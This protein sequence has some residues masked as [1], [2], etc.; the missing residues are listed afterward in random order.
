MKRIFAVVLAVVMVVLMATPVLAREPQMVEDAYAAWDGPGEWEEPGYMTLF[1]NGRPSTPIALTLADGWVYANLQD[2]AYALGA[3]AR[4]DSQTGVVHWNPAEGGIIQ[5]IAFDNIRAFDEDGIAWVCREFVWDVQWMTTGW[6]FGPTP[7]RTDIPPAAPV[8][9]TTDHGQMAVDFI[10]YMNDNLYNRVPFSYRELEAAQWIRDELIAMGYDEDA[11]VLQSF[12]IEDA[13]AFVGPFSGSLGIYEQFNAFDPD[14]RL[15]L[16]SAVDAMI[17]IALEE[18]YEWIARMAEQMGVSF[19]EAL[20]MMAEDHGI[21][22]DMFHKLLEVAVRDSAPW[23]LNFANVFGLFDLDT[24]FRPYSQNVVLT[25][26]GQSERKIVVTAHYDSIMVPGASDNASGTALLLESAYR[27]MDMD[28]YFTIVYVFMGAEEIGLLGA[29]YYVENLSN[30]ERNNIVLNINADVLIEGPYFF[31]GAGIMDDFWLEDNEITL[32]IGDIA[33]ELNDSYGT[34]LIN[35]QP[36]AEMPSDQLPFLWGGHTVVTLVGLAR[37]G[38]EGYEE[39]LN[40]DMY[41]GF[42]SSIVHTEFDCFHFI[43][44]TWPNKI[45]D[46]MWTFSVFL[47][48]LLAAEF[49]YEN[50]PQID[51]NIFE[52]VEREEV[53]LTNHPMVGTWTWDDNPE[54]SYVFNADG[55]GVRGLPGQMVEFYWYADDYDVFIDMENGNIT[56]I[57]QL[58]FVDDEMLILGMQWWHSFS[59]S[60]Q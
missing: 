33:E 44:E 32:L 53:D 57:W 35:A 27:L 60:R 6:H 1:I 22:A 3:T 55:T 7:V 12:T 17:A 42:S 18:E 51:V 8:V 24:Q 45:G 2:A 40:W 13:A 36:L 38:S 4:L 5:S 29:Y 14:Q 16:D 54:W 11:V 10:E 34:A 56:E 59:Y 30:E 50:L 47:E 19:E 21:F 52:P 37:T 49:D 41:P 28:N 46:S 26:P 15:D 39:F 48:Y 43:N 31:F 25:V 58:L 9:R 20:A 23:R